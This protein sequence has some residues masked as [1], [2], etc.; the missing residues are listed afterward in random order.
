MDM[1]D[2]MYADCRVEVTEVSPYVLLMSAVNVRTGMP[3]LLES[4]VLMENGNA[5]IRSIQ[6]FSG[7]NGICDVFVMHEMRV[8]N[9]SSSELTPFD[10]RVHLR[11]V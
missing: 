3:V 6:D 4:V 1:S 8:M 10:D 9:P 5:R 7:G 11:S 2:G